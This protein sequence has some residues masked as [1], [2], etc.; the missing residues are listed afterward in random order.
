MKRVESLPDTTVLRRRDPF[1]KIRSLDAPYVARVWLVH[2][3]CLLTLA[4]TQDGRG[5]RYR[6]RWRAPH[7]A[8]RV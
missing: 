7:V 1:S 3:G 2:L 5:P 8:A 4:V 6:R